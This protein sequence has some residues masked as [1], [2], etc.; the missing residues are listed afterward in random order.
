MTL[1]HAF[2]LMTQYGTTLAIGGYL[3]KNDM[4]NI[5][6]MT[7]L[8]KGSKNYSALKTLEGLLLAYKKLHKMRESGLT[9][10]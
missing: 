6:K 1:E 4:D 2:F 5:E 3:D 7:S 10:V 8:F 9:L